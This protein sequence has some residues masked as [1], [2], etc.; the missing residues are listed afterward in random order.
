MIV[1]ILKPMIEDPVHKSFGTSLAESYRCQ[2]IGRAL[3]TDAGKE[4]V[5]NV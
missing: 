1:D 4:S 5:I 2:L 3:E